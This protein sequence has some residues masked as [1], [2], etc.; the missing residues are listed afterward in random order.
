MIQFWLG[1]TNW[2]IT[3]VALNL[4]LVLVH[5]FN[6]LVL[7]KYYLLGTLVINLGT[8]LPPL[9]KGKF[10]WDDVIGV[11]WLTSADSNDRSMCPKAKGF[12]IEDQRE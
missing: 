3:C 7:E 12:D 8:T 2:L 11:C 4:E 9:I 10:G 1:V 6:G 5:L